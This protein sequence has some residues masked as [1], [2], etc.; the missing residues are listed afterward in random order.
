MIWAFSCQ[1]HI[2]FYGSKH[3]CQ[4]IVSDSVAVVKYVIRDVGYFIVSGTQI[5]N[6][7]AI[8]V[9]RA[10]ASDIINDNRKRLLY[11]LF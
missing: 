3:K 8:M 6:E 5:G 7:N 9:G 1:S 4:Y 10:F 2:T 11:L